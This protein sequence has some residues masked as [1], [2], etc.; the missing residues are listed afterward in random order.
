MSR[1]GF[2]KGFVSGSFAFC[3][4]L[5]IGCSMQPTKA[6]SS[7]FCPAFWQQ[8]RS[9]L[10][11]FPFDG[12][13]AAL[14][15]A[16]EAKLFRAIWFSPNGR[17]VYGQ[18]LQAPGGRPTGLIKVDFS[19][20]RESVVP[21]S[22]TLSS[23]RYLTVSLPTGKVFVAGWIEKEGKR[24]CGYFEIN[25]DSATVRTLR[26]GTIVDCRQGLGPISPNGEQAVVA[27]GK[28]LGLLNFTTGAFQTLR[29]M[30]AAD[31]CS[32]S[33]DGTSLACVGR[34]KIFVLDISDFRPR[35]VGGPGDSRPKW[36]PDGSS[37][38]VLQSQLSCIPTL[39][40]DSLAVIDVHTGKKSWIKSAHCAV[41]GGSEYGWVDRGVAR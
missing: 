26:T 23:I 28:G 5:G 9:E 20:T 14:P 8:G 40:G 38:L 35:R 2:L 31:T 27:S 29:G 17:S 12:N 19:P 24:E 21:G 3:I 30:S 25:P 1:R 10:K 4:S 13:E 7:A 39:Y 11:L 37:L 32:W 34:R 16:S 36:S 33:P 6:D 22:E 15:L 41:A 18:A